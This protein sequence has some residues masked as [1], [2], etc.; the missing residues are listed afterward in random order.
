MSPSRFKSADQKYN[1]PSQ[2]QYKVGEL[3]RKALVETFERVEIRDPDLANTS[4]TVSEVSVS[5]DLKAA[6]VF[7]MP[8]AGKNCEKVITGLERAKT[9]LRNEVAK[10]VA[11]K[12]MPRLNF[13][14]DTAFDASQH[15]D[16]LLKS[17]DHGTIPR[18][19]LEKRS[20]ETTK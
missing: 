8:L 1:G 12:Y 19:R 3:I 10:R 4:I 9:F 7:V 20:N 2:R 15:L 16:Q 17:D 14:I 5:P 18:T 6:K 11:L 13:K